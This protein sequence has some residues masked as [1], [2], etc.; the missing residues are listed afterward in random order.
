[1]PQR[2]AHHRVGSLVGLA[3]KRNVSLSELTDEEIKSVDATLDGKIRRCPGGYGG[4]RSVPFLRFKPAFAG[5]R[6]N[7]DMEEKLSTDH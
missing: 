1:M 6:S 2:T 4:R 3:R 5:R 7:E